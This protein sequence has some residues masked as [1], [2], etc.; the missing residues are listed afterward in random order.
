M[1]IQVDDSEPAFRVEAGRAPSIRLYGVRHLRDDQ[2][3]NDFVQQVLA[4]TLD[5]LRV[6]RLREPERLE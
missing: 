3:A 1:E 4:I 2:A 6:G 5:A